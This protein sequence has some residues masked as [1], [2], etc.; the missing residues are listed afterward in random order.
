M[1][2]ESHR[3]LIARCGCIGLGVGL[4]LALAC[5]SNPTQSPPPAPPVDT[6]SSTFTN[7]LNDS[8]PD[9][10]LTYY[11]GNYYLAATT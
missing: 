6:S 5:T 11:E 2:K 9:P 8:G 4:A 1:C 10:W 3:R 7:P